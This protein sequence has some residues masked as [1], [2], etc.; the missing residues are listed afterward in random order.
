MPRPGE[1]HPRSETEWAAMLCGLQQLSHRAFP[2]R[3]LVRWKSKDVCAA[4]RQC[5]ELAAVGQFDRRQ[6]G[7]VSTPK[8]FLW[9]RQQVTAN[10]SSGAC[11]SFE[12]RVL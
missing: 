1:V 3:L 6:S 10:Q 9:I 5:F 12:P 4:V 2:A 7:K 8:H 11:R